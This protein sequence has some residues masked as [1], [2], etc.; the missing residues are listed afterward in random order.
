MGGWLLNLE[1]TMVLV[2]SIKNYSK[3]QSGKAQVQYKKF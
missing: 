1:R 3:V 2:L